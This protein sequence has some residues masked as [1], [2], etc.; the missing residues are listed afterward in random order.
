MKHSAGI[1]RTAALALT[2]VLAGCATYDRTKAAQHQTQAIAVSYTA[3]ELSG[4][5]DL[6]IGT[7]RVPDSQVIV[8]GHQK[9]A[10]VGAAFGL[11]GVAIEHSMEKSAGHAAV[12]GSEQV[13]HITLTGEGQQDL[14]VLLQSDEFRGKFVPP[15]QGLAAPQ[16]TLSG[17]VILTFIDDTNVMPFVVL[18]A[19]L[20]QP[21][22][23]TEVWWTRYICGLGAPKA[24]TGDNS[25]S[26]DGGAALRAAV[27]AEL[28]RALHGALTDVLA[29]AARDENHQ[30]AVAGYYPFV[31]GRFELVGYDLAED[32]QSVMFAPRIGDANVIAG[33]SI[34]D[35]AIVVTRPATKS[36]KAFRRLDDKPA[37]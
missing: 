31:R 3:E 21:K 32:S 16:L 11:L 22:P 13:L 36:D 33:I 15:A 17:A 6:P 30:V 12:Q 29:P 24:L 19:R 23:A 5:S 9:G 35:R 7:Y 37:H 8:S 2:A 18:R 25:W 14:D 10:G 34:M 4:W 20:S 28:A 26:A 1:T 27:S